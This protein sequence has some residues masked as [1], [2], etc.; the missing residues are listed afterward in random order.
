MQFYGYY[1]NWIGESEMITIVMAT[2]NGENYIHKQLASIM[3]Q[4]RIPD[5]IIIVDDSSSDSTFKIIEEFNLKYNKIIN[6]N[7]LKNEV[8]AGVVKAFNK[9]IHNSSGDLIFLCDQDDIWESD[10]VE[11]MSNIMNNKKEILALNAGYKFINSDDKILK[12]KMKFSNTISKV[13]F[14]LVIKNNISP[15]CTMVFRKEL[16]QSIKELTDEI[17]IHDWYINIVA[18]LFDGLYYYDK[19]VIEYRLHDKNVIGKDRGIIT[20]FSKNKKTKRVLDLNNRI[21]LYKYIKDYIL[22]SNV[23]YKNDK[24]NTLNLIITFINHRIEFISSRKLSIY[25]TKIIPNKNL[26]YAKKVMWAD[27]FYYMIR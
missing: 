1:I 6:I 26:Y 4:T 8:N 21:M 19:N 24:L 7:I 13:D 16:I 23:V 14:N 12:G 2:Y 5:E 3:N 27:V 20:K 10:K 25:L 22:K 18:S 17:Y 11:L 15:G 9:A